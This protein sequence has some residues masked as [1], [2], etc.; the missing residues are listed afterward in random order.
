VKK[1]SP[2]RVGQFPARSIDDFVPFHRFL[3]ARAILAYKARMI[4][5]DEELHDRK[6]I[7]D[8]VRLAFGRTADAVLVDQLRADGDSVVF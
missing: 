1:M 4:I 3:A 5:R 7:D 6:A 2:F 8:A